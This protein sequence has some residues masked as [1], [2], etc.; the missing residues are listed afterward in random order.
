MVLVPLKLVNVLSADLLVYA[1]F[2]V[3]LLWVVVFKLP[4]QLSAETKMSNGP[5]KEAHAVGAQRPQAS[6]PSGY[7]TFLA[8]CSI[9]K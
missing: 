2:I 3:T 4:T 9:L 5:T 8:Q 1:I 7:F 6:S